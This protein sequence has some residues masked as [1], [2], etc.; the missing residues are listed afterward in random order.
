MKWC[1][2]GMRL[3]VMVSLFVFFDFALQSVYA[4]K[5]PC[6]IY[7]DGKTP[8]VAAHSMVRALFESYDGPLYQVRRTSDNK[9]MD[10]PLKSKGGYVNAAVQDSFLGGKPGTISKIYDQSEMGNHLVK[11]PIG[12]WLYQPA[13]E[14][15]AN[16]TM[17]MINGNKA[18]GC[19][20]HRHMGYR[21]NTT[22]GIAT[23]AQ[24]EGIYMVASGKSVNDSCCY[25][26]GNAETNMKNNGTGTMETI[27]WGSMCYPGFGPCTGKGPWVFADLENGLFQGGETGRNAQNLTVICDYV[28]AIVK[29]NSKNYSIRAGDAQNGTLKTMASKAPR[30]APN[31]LEG[32]I[33][34]GVG[35]DNSWAARGIFFEGAITSGEPSDSIEDAVQKNIINAGYGKIAVKIKRGHVDQTVTENTVG[36]SYDCSLHRVVVNYGLVESRSVQFSIYDQQGRQIARIINANR[37]SGWHTAFWGARVPAGIYFWNVMVEGVFSKSGK[38]VVR[39]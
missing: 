20:T 26:Y 9:T 8:C 10:I 7:K 18:Y 37:T 21:N 2:P 31:K 17:I 5:C 15:I 22:K 25:D 6:D 19:Y 36:V 4:E 23:G 16:D 34:L 13:D 12:G 3:G 30:P 14:A 39:K 28:T 27:Y 11:S 32:A 33:V 38:V 24:S 1:A 29:G 35:G